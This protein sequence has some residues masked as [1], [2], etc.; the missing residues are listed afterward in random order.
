M[1]IT[2]ILCALEMPMYNDCNRK[3]ILPPRYQISQS[4]WL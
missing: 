3:Q 2:E 1:A 4:L